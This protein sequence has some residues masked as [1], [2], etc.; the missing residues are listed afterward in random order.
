MKICI[1]IIYSGASRSVSCGDRINS[2]TSMDEFRDETYLSMK[3]ILKNFYSKF[4][5]NDVYYY[6]TQFREVQTESIELI[7]NDIYVKGNESYM[8]IL[9]KTIKS[10]E[11]MNKLHIDYDFLIRA[12][13]S[14]IIDINNL[15]KFLNSIPKN[16]IYCGGCKLNLQW[17]D[18]NYG[19]VDD[20]LFGLNYIQ[21]T[22]IILSKNIVESI[23]N[24]KDKLNYKIIDDV[25]IGLFIKKYHNNIFVDT[26][27]LNKYNNIKVNVDQSVFMKSYG[28][29]NCLES[30]DNI[31]NKNIVF[32]RNRSNLNKVDMARMEM[33]S[34][35]LIEIYNL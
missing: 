34:K 20:T 33:I 19:I 24:N 14:T 28:E 10:F 32:Y 1:L 2:G 27:N 9:D 29:G 7:E 35:C 25:S 8:N 4:K 5:N 15:L 17:L 30:I 26:H 12:N 21:G 3:N 22:S 16:N 23:C 13:I 11:L 6:F 31:Q 18:P